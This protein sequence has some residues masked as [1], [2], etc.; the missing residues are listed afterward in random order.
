MNS[1][2]KKKKRSLYLVIGVFVL[3]SSSLIG[4]GQKNKQTNARV[5]LSF[6]IAPP[7]SAVQTKK[8]TNKKIPIPNK[9]NLKKNQTI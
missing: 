4:Y 6:R 3:P 9:T 7:S 1:E 8:Q 2:R 5:F